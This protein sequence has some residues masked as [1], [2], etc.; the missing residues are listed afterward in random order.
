M[1]QTLKKIFLSLILSLAFFGAGAYAAEP[2][3]DA[4]ALVNTWFKNGGDII[5]EA[6]ISL[7]ANTFVY[8]DVTLDLNGHTLSIGN[9]TLVPYKATLTVKDTFENADGKITSSANPVIQ[10]G[11]K[12]QPGSLVL[13]SGIIESTAT[14]GFTIHNL[15]YGSFVMNGGLIIGPLYAVRNYNT[16]VLNDGEVRGDSFVVYNQKDFEMKG[17]TINV[18]GGGPGVYVGDDTNETNFVMNGGLITVAGDASSKSNV[19]VNLGKP[20][21]HFTMNGG[22]IESLFENA[23]YGGTAVT[24][25]EDSTVV[26]NDGEIIGYSG[27]LMGNGSFHDWGNSG[28]RANFTINGGTLTATNGIGVY[29]PQPYGATTITGGT[30]TGY[31]TGVEVRAGDL[32]ISGGVIK[33]EYGSYEAI[34]NTNGSTTYGA[35]VSV[36]QHT[37]KQPINVLVSGG[38]F[39]A[40]APISF[41]NPLE[42]S[43]EILDTVHITITGGDF[44][45]TVTQAI[46]NGIVDNVEPITGGTYSN[47]VAGFVATGYGEY[48]K[49]NKF[50]VG[51]THTIVVSE[52]SADYIVTLPNAAVFGETVEFDIP[53]REDYIKTVSVKDA[54]NA[55]VAVDGDHFTMPDDDVTLSVSWQFIYRILSGANQTV[56]NAEPTDIV[57]TSNGD[58]NK[59]VSIKVDGTVLAAEQYELESGSTIL[60]LLADYLKTLAAGEHLLTFVYEDGYISTNFTVESAPEEPEEPEP[61]GP[62]EPTEPEEEPE[63]EIA[64]PNTGRFGNYEKSDIKSDNLCYILAICCGVTALLMTGVKLAKCRR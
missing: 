8:K 7:S 46:F 48:K 33:S 55:A 44:N 36:A 19:G 37:T 61:T 41:T 13:E 60:T 14:S 25:F 22:R 35:A 42:Y 58:L 4:D 26:I 5:L 29:S 18:T 62:T 39:E 47:S 56:E 16:F 59:L 38:S 21:S 9:K 45:S 52:G 43:Q 3:S 32:T 40:P 54:T 12:S 11:T 17:G 15:N 28:E 2:V 49:D 10:I 31:Q 20:F 27:A 1:K 34:N 63:E 53:D 50:H 30:I 6:D 64:V 57:V 23:K 24:G 51:P